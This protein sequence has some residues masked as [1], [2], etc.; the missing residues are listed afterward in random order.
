MGEAYFVPGFQEVIA[1]TAQTAPQGT[2]R[3]GKIKS[4]GDVVEAQCVAECSISKSNTCS[5]L[6]SPFEV[7]SKFR[8]IYVGFRIQ[9]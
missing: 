9:A 4:S 5:N 7:T 3:L 8:V 1:R 2:F 6:Q